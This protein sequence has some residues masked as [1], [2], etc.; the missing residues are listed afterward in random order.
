MRFDGKI[1]LITGAG[2]GIGKEYA[3]ALA[4]EGAAVVIADIDGAVGESAAKEII[5][6]GGRAR[7]VQTDVASDED[8]QGTVAETTRAFGG[9]DILVNNAGLHLL[10]YGV[11][12]TTLGA[13]KWRRLLDVNL[14]GPLHLAAACRSSMQQRG[15]G[16]IVNQSSTASFTPT[17]AYGVSK[18]ALNALTVALAAE[19][20]EDNIR[21][22]GIAP[23]LVDSPAALAALP[24]EMQQSVI[25]SQALKRMGLMTD[26]AAALVFLCSDEAAFIT[27]QTFRVDGGAVKQT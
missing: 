13:D 9:V 7:A 24:E 26:L 25:N 15:G 19:F 10:E 6:A 14:T 1:A 16:V 12:C 11:P 21:V 17:G 4:A 3:R 8:V 2:A 20:G 5:A 22:V 18:L 27:G 23:T